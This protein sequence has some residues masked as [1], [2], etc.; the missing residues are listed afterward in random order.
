MPVNTKTRRSIVSVVTSWA[1]MVAFAHLEFWT[2]FG[3]DSVSF[4]GIDLHG[5]GQTFRSAS[6]LAFES[7]WTRFAQLGGPLVQGP[8]KMKPHYVKMLRLASRGGFTF[9]ARKFLDAGS[10]G[11]SRS[12]RS[13]IEFDLSSAYG[14]SSSNALMPSGF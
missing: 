14:Y 3:R 8:E 2:K 5:N 11:G 13:I 4:F 12:R 6:L 7:V 1:R 10:D 9:S